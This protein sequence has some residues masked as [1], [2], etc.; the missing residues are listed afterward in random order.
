[1]KPNIVLNWISFKFFVKMIK[2]E[3]L[4]I[5]RIGLKTSLKIPFFFFFLKVKI[6]IEAS[7]WNWKPNNTSINSEVLCFL[8]SRG[9]LPLDSFSKNNFN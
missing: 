6:E 5:Q 9:L 7:F 1:M 4:K 3:Y 8:N 2:T